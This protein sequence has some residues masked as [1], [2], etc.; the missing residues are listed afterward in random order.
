MEFMLGDHILYSH[1]FSD[2][3]SF[4]ITNKNLTFIT[5][6]TLSVKKLYCCYYVIYLFKVEMLPFFRTSSRFAFDSLS[7]ENAILQSAQIRGFHASCLLRKLYRFWKRGI[8]TFSKPSCHKSYSQ[9]VFFFW[10]LVTVPEN[11]PFSSDL[12][13][14]LIAGMFVTNFQ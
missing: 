4:D 13:S 5:I 3:E 8:N 10:V 1:D 6:R 11:C 7:I 2:W 14:L 9:S 12:N